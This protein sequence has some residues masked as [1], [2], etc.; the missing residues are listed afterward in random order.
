MRKRT[1]VLVY[2]PIFFLVLVKN[3]KKKVDVVHIT[4][5]VNSRFTYFPFA[6]S[7]Y[8]LFFL[9]YNAYAEIEHVVFLK[10]FWNSSH[11]IALY[12]FTFLKT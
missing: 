4:L 8:V 6:W 9:F 2:K 12:F 1:F 3:E 11:S 10:L 5:L 7:I